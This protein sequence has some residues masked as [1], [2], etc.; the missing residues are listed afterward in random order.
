MLRCAHLPALALSACAWLAA[1]GGGG[2]AAAS[3]A[4]A[5][6]V[7]AIAYGSTTY[8]YTVGIAAQT[9]TPKN[10]SSIGSWSVSP[11]LPAGLLLSG[12]TGAISGTPMADSPTT[13][14]VIKGITSTGQPASGDLSIGVT[15][16]VVLNLGEV[17]AIQ[18]IEFDSAHV[19]TEDTSANWIL[20]NAATTQQIASG[21]AT[22]IVE[23]PEFPPLSEPAPMALAGSV[24]LIQKQ[25]GLELRSSATGA[26]LAEIAMHLQWWKLATDGSYVCAGSDSALTCWSPSGQQLFSEP[27][28]YYSAMVLAAPSQLL[29]AFGAAGPQVIET[30]STATWTASVGA[31][32]Q[33]RFSSWF[34]DGSQFL[35]TIPEGTQVGTTLAAF[36][37]LYVYSPASVLEDT[38]TMPTLQGLTGQGGWFWTASPTSALTIYPV[39]HN[40]TACMPIPCTMPTPNA[41]YPLYAPL[42]AID[43]FIASIAG[44]ALTIID[45]SGATPLEMSFTLPVASPSAFAAIGPSRFVLGT[46]QG[47]IVEGSMSAAPR[48]FGYGAV[49]NLVGGAARAVFTTASG[50]TFSFNTTS[51][52]FE[53]TLDLAADVQ[54][55]L[56]V[57][58]GVLAGL[59]G[60]GNVDIY[61]MPAG[62][63]I[64]NFPASSNGAG[65]ASISLSPPGTMLGEM[66]NND[67]DATIPVVGGTATVYANAG[68]ALLFSPDGALAAVSN[69]GWPPG[70]G[71]D[72][73]GPPPTT[74][75]YQN[76][77][78]LT[79]VPGWASQWLSNSSFLVANYTCCTG[80]PGGGAAVFTG[81]Q[82]YTATGA[83]ES[84]P[85]SGPI[86]WASADPASNSAVAGALAVLVSGNL[87]IAQP[88]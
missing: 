22:I 43:S 63:L 26:V 1:C 15:S 79:T 2:G 11:A 25:S 37:T 21:I 87:V 80:G 41:T 64:H 53:P 60:S 84:T 65:P 66:F 68:A 34:V 83:A 29:V 32:F 31:A 77:T 9:L 40:T 50:S 67:T 51:N 35:T 55:A 7:V 27:G 76:G 33:G 71:S 24:I 14:Y 88:F 8:Q 48:Y 39:G 62:P 59:D 3:S 23:R 20:W 75:I 56:S 57:N 82:A 52:A 18:F 47:V 46:R 19:L 58:G 61:S 6:T 70:Y 73:V 16:T 54:L 4:P 10:P 30:V 69:S 13:T 38:E 74:R 12:T 44:N 17:D 85:V 49:T 28:N 86:T 42:T 36:N 5:P 78:L 72:Y 45:L 81:Y